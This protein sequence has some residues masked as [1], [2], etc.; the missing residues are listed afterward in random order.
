MQEPFLALL[1]TDQVAAWLEALTDSFCCAFAGTTSVPR[2]HLKY[3]NG[4]RH[5]YA[6][7]L[8]AVSLSNHFILLLIYLS[9][10]AVS[11]PAKKLPLFSIILHGASTFLLQGPFIY[12]GC[13]VVIFNLVSPSAW[14]IVRQIAVLK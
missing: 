14:K 12:L 6:W 9:T 2:R 4:L 13:A 3:L 8:T 1:V 10:T 5:D 7:L 11:V